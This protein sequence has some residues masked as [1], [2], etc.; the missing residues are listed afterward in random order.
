MRNSLLCL[1]KNYKRSVLRR[2]EFESAMVI[3]DL[4]II[5]DSINAIALKT[6]LN[7]RSM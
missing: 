2:I 1:K 4:L 3:E 5:M 6:L 7:C